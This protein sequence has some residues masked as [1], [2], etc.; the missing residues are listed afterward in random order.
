MHFLD[1]ETLLLITPGVYAEQCKFYPVPNKWQNVNIEID[2]P[3]YNNSIISQLQP[4][5]CEV[6]VFVLITFTY[7]V[8][9]LFYQV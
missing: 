2:I 6:L 5:S 1:D 4:Y 7:I 3:T 8:L 9:K